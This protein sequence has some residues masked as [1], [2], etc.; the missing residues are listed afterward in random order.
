M[1]KLADIPL[2]VLDL[3]TVPR[4]GTPRQA[5]ER[6]IAVA[7]LAEK[8]GFRRFWLAEHHNLP[9]IASAATAVLI[10]HVAA[11]TGHIR[12]G[13]GG[14]MLPNH[15]PL[16]IAEQFGTLASL[17]PGR[18]DL[19][20]GRAPGTDPLTA[21]AIRGATAALEPDFS[22]MLEEL[23]RYLRP[24]EPGRKV[25]AIPGEGLDVPLWLLGSSGYSAQLAGQLGLPFAFASHFAPRHVLAALELYRSTF[26]PSEAL[27]A[28]YAM[29][30][31]NVVVA[32]TSGQ[33]EHLATSLRQRFLRMV[34]NRRGP[35]D[36]PVDDMAELWSDEERALVESML[37]ASAIGD[38]ASATQQMQAFLDA[39]LADEIIVSTDIYALEDRLRS[40]RL[41]AECLGRL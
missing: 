14:V 32:E 5:F 3:A 29:V 1:T 11:H 33:A 27:S 39:T 19:G 18:I 40:F 17:Y 21:R 4:G 41:L 31:M 7:Q 16:I 34:R 30:A 25:R 23:C 28:P 35:L 12:V 38:P 13:S 36:P 24:A 37:Q 26:Q 2:S 22:V 9:G 6:T 15:A 10:G 8:A 20:L